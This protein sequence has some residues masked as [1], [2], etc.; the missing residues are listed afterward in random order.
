[1]KAIDV[2]NTTL[3]IYKTNR[4]RKYD[5]N[6]AK[7]HDLGEAHCVVCDEVFTKYHYHTKTCSEECKRERKSETCRKWREE[8]REKERARQ[9][10]HYVENRDEKLEY[11]RK[12][13]AKKKEMNE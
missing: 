9:R 3:S 4:H 12:Y 10:K 13:R 6:Q 11:A 5:A 2:S 7:R 8:N 1:M